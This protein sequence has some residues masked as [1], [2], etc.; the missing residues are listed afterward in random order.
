MIGANVSQV[1]AF[2]FD[3]PAVTKAVDR[4]SLAV[5]SRFGAYVRTAAQR[6]MPYATKKGKRSKPSPAGLPPR[7]I[8]P[9]PWVR[10]HLYFAFDPKKRS[11]VVGPAAFGSRTGAPEA[12]EYGGATQGRNPRRTLRRYGGS[13]EI[14]IDSPRSGPSTKPAVDA[15]GRSRL[16]TYAKLFSY[17]QV[18]RAN[19]IQEELYGPLEFKGS[20]RARPFMRPALK[21]E[22]PKLPR[23]WANSIK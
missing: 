12:L 3:R 13:G 9:H 17:G 20:M 16:V 23:M 18:A 22:L 19:Q 7:A 8:K 5:L 14:L 1:K 6:S 10:Q 21:A 2:F 4:G 15:R 11:V